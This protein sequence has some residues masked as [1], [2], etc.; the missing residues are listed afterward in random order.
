M[1]SNLAYV[2]FIFY[3]YSF[4][5]Y[6][7]PIEGLCGKLKYRANIIHHFICVFCIYFFYHSSCRKD[8]FTGLSLKFGTQ[9][10][11]DSGL[12]RI[13]RTLTR[14]CRCGFAFISVSFELND[15]NSRN[16]G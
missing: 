13:R 14:V 3:L 4:F 6:I 16:D 11:T 5:L 1:Y 8:Q 15:P 7:A 12:L 2:P 10:F 9:D